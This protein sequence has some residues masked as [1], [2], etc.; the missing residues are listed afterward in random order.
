MDRQGVEKTRHLNDRHYVVCEL[1]TKVPPF[2]LSSSGPSALPV[3]GHTRHREI[4]DLYEWE[5]RNHVLTDHRSVRWGRFL[6]QIDQRG[7]RSGEADERTI[8]DRLVCAH[9][10]A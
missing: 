10:V 4:E 2:A 3:A 7:P 5:W 1:G 6:C 8:E 9:G